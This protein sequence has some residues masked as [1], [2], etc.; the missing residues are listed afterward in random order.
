MPG[1]EPFSAHMKAEPSNLTA[2]AGL[3]NTWTCIAQTAPFQKL[4]TSRTTFAPAISASNT[5]EDHRSI[6]RLHFILES[7]KGN[8]RLQMSWRYAWILQAWATFALYHNEHLDICSEMTSNALRNVC[9]KGIATDYKS[10]WKEAVGT[11]S[12]VRVGIHILALSQ[13][14]E[15]H[16]SWKFWN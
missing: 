4:I 14:M 8:V 16:E 10:R 13:L 5:I 6:H 3:T 1:E 12:R 9:E 15:F 7:N 2:S 11:G